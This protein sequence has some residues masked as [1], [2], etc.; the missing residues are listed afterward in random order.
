MPLDEKKEKRNFDCD[1]CSLSFTDDLNLNNHLLIYH[2]TSSIIRGDIGIPIRL[3]GIKHDTGKPDLSH[4]SLELAEVV[5]R[6]R[7]FGAK[8]YARNNWRIGF[9]YTRS[10]AAALRHVMAF[11][12]GQDLDPE[13]GLS[14]IGH[15]IC[16]LEHLLNDIKNH[17]ENDDR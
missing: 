3:E 9:K 16:C 17:P 11:N 4:I 12:E 5:A 13:S 6:V 10:V 1:S 8:K 7:E 14:H 15:A 2:N